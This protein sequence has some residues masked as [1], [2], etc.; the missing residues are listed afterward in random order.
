MK[1]DGFKYYVFDIILL[2]AHLPSKN[3]KS[4]KMEQNPIMSKE[5]IEVRMIFLKETQ[6]FF[7]EN[8]ITEKS[9]KGQ[10][11]VQLSDKL[12]NA[13]LDYLP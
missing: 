3:R 4:K 11:F 10:Q 9:V 13:I 1:F 12:T 8:K 5:E 6:N 2:Q 7:K